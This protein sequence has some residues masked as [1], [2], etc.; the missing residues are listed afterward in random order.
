MAA[1]FDHQVL[2]PAQSRLRLRK[3]LIVT[4]HDH[5]TFVIE[6]PL[7]GK[8]FL[9]GTAEWSFLAQLDGSG[10]IAEAIGRSATQAGREAAL[11]EQEGVAVARWL[12]DQSLA[13]PVAHLL[14]QRSDDGCPPHVRTARF[15]P[16]SM[17]I[18]SLNPDRFLAAINRRLSWIWSKQ[19]LAVWLCLAAASVVKLG[20]H[21][22]ALNVL[23]GD[24]LD[25]DNW[26]RMAGVWC[27]LKLMHEMAHGLSCRNFGIPVRR[28]GLLLIF[29]APVPFVDVSGA[30]RLPS[31]WQRIVISG[32]GMYVEL[33]TAFAAL[34][35]WTPGSLELFD[36]LC[37][38][39]FMLAGLNTLLFNANP[40]M[41]FDGYYILADALGIPNLSSQGQRCWAN[42]VK[43]WFRGVDVAPVRDTHFNRL[44]IGSYGF[45]S[46]G[47]RC[48]TFAGIALSLI[49][50]WSW[51]GGA[52]SIFVGWFWFNFTWPD[53]SNPAPDLGGLST[54]GLRRRRTAWGALGAAAL[55]MTT[56]LASP[57]H[58]TAPAIVEYA[59]LSVLRAKASGFVT[60]VHV[61]K[62]E[63]VDAGTL[64]LELTNDELNSNLKRVEVELAQAELRSRA[65]LN[66]YEIPKQQKELAL[67]AS[68]EQQRAELR[69]Q[70]DGLQLRAP[71]SATVASRDVATLIGRYVEKG[72]VLL[73]LGAENEKE[74]LVSVASTDEQEFVAQLNESVT[75]YRESQRAITTAGR[76]AHVDPRVAETLPHAALGADSGG[77]V[78]VKLD[79]RLRDEM[80]QASHLA[81][82]PRVVAKVS[83]DAA[84]SR[85]FRAGQRVTVSLSGTQ[86]SWGGRILALWCDYLTELSARSEPTGS[87]GPH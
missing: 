55:L 52:A 46:S 16:L 13:Q 42:T 3:D 64:L 61:R 83:L 43:H 11:T 29:M 28:A 78:V 30:W 5:A 17:R 45:L 70:S 7:S 26:L 85:Q 1:A 80:K 37:L 74:L 65:F 14:G 76:L 63:T 71:H 10:T 44:A 48:L 68:L 62:G 69:D 51:W 77:D 34:M 12:V 82:T 20:R 47:W 54:R 86:Q 41:R 67:V 73:L 40:L 15:N 27:F 75:V 24:I 25:R 59:P 36:R 19:F 4:P 39:V 6:D 9:V 2:D 35:L 84:A 38:D 21:W 53:R 18:A 56:W 79:G 8:F 87:T 22:G 60:A 58:V 81:L 66:Q 23:P 32:A 49:A 31:R 33:F 57:A 72:E 50:G